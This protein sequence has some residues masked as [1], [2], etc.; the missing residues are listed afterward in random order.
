MKIKREKEI[1][2]E[3][4]FVVLRKF[5]NFEIIAMPVSFLLGYTLLF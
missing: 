5:V 1:L 4:V 3:N 2:D